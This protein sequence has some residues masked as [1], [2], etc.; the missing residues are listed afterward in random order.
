MSTF[1]LPYV[2]KCPQNDGFFIEKN[3][4]FFVAQFS[5]E[6]EVS[7]RKL[8]SLALISSRRVQMLR[9]SKKTLCAISHF[10]RA[11]IAPKNVKVVLE[12][13]KEAGSKNFFGLF[14]KAFRPPSGDIARLLIHAHSWVK[15][16]LQFSHT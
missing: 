16:P 14:W 3:A 7:T 1:T 9:F 6:F 13:R 2:E 12:D 10:F 4:Q 15:W 11:K 5:A 8:A